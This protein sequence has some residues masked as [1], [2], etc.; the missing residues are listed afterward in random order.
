MTKQ[1][2]L[3]ARREYQRQYRAK[4]KAVVA[5][6][7]AEKELVAQILE[8]DPSLLNIPRRDGLRN[9]YDDGMPDTPQLIQNMSQW[10]RDQILGALPKSARKTTHTER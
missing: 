2:D 6:P 4:K 9:P 5:E 10:H 3:E 7:I 1:Y 8:E